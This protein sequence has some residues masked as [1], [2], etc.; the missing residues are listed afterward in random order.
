MEFSFL[1]SAL[2]QICVISQIFCEELDEAHIRLSREV[3][4]LN[5]ELIKMKTPQNTI[6]I[7]GDLTALMTLIHST[8]NV[9][10]SGG[11]MK[12]YKVSE[13]LMSSGSVFEK[14]RI[15]RLDMRW[16]A[17]LR[18]YL[19]TT[20]EDVFIPTNGIDGLLGNTL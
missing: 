2:R 18:Y 7:G 10:A 3:Q 5:L 15:I 11:V 16:A 12:L 1:R 8:E 9:L 13:E 17:M 6:V 4:R 14:S 19:G 20:F